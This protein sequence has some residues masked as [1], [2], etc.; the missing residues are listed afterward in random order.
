MTLLALTITI[1]L[2]LVILDRMFEWLDQDERDGITHNSRE[3]RHR[4]TNE[5]R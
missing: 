5:H 2:L 4:R 3:D 1:G